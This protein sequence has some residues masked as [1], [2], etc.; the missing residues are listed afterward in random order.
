MNRLNEHLTIVNHGS[1]VKLTN[2]ID[3]KKIVFSVFELYHCID[4]DGTEY[5]ET[6]AGWVEVP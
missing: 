2:Q 3:E 5:R 6:S 4:H 1:I